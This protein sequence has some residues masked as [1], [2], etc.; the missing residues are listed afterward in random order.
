[1]F[2]L[3]L[4][5]TIKFINK[6][7]EKLTI[8]LITI[9]VKHWRHVFIIFFIKIKWGKL[10]LFPKTNIESH[11]TTRS[12]T[13]HLCDI[14]PH[15]QRINMPNETQSAD[16]SVFWRRKGKE[17]N[18]SCSKLCYPP[19]LP[20]FFGFFCLFLPSSFSLQKV[21]WLLNQY[22]SLSG[23]RSFTI[24]PL[25]KPNK[26]DKKGRKAMRR[27]REGEKESAKMGMKGF[28]FPSPPAPILQHPSFYLF[29]HISLFIWCG[30]GKRGQSLQS[31]AVLMSNH[32][33]LHSCDLGSAGV[34]R[35]QGIVG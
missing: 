17:T 24:W 22:N 15:M 7:V 35:C 4:A 31:F 3:S 12:C 18:Q 1:M 26:P 25:S 28:S 8:F 23:P 13:G 5:N 6:H 29:T 14:P 11:T 2:T 34:G 16:R 19:A 27:E 9:F 32:A 33:P 20:A 21:C 30:F 10:W